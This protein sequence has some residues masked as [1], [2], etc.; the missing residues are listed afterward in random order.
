[1]TEKYYADLIKAIADSTIKRLWII[2]IILTILLFATNAA[3]IYYESTF[4]DETW[5]I[6]AQTD[7][8]GDAIANGNGE[9]TYNGNGESNAHEA[10]P[11][12]G[13]QHRICKMQ[14]LWW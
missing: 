11:Q 10:Y 2:I 6:E 9:V 12:V 1:M 8:G 7:D 5:T 4:I 14:E 13:R 3:W